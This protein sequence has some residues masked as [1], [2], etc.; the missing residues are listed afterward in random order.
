MSHKTVYRKVTLL[1]LFKF[2]LLRNTYLNF[3]VTET[4][5]SKEKKHIF[6]IHLLQIY[7]DY[8]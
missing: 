5:T 6:Q 4:L 7:I 2:Y 3:T 1:D 8:N